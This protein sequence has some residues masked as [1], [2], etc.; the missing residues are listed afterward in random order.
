MLTY[1]H[2]GVRSL[3]VVLLA[4]TT[5][6]IAPLLA[7]AQE[8]TPTP[9]PIL[10]QDPNAPCV[11]SRLRVGDLEGVDDT[12]DAGLERITREA[13]AWHPDARLYTLRL[14]CRL[15][16]TGVQ[17]EGVFFSETAQALYSTDTARVDAVND[18]PE[19]IPTLNPSGLSLRNVHRSLIRAGFSDDMQLTALGGVTIRQSTSTHPFGPPSAPRDEVY[20]HLAIDVDGVIT[21]VWVSM[22][23]YTIYRYGS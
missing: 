7:Q 10:G 22:Q 9:R 13:E 5:L 2:S 3:L 18:A 1:Y 4:T 6:L 16:A 21:D 20:A 19:T 23:D 15:L 12:I 11:T 14:G 8:V 17:W